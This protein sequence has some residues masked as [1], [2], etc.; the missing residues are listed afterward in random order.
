MVGRLTLMLVLGR[1]SITCIE[2]ETLFGK[3]GA[4]LSYSSTVLP[5]SWQ[6]CLAHFHIDIHDTSMLLLC[7]FAVIGM[8]GPFRSPD[9]FPRQPWAIFS[10]WTHHASSIDHGTPVLEHS[11]RSNNAR[12]MTDKGKPLDYMWCR[13]SRSKGLVDDS[14]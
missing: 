13:R 10:V 4:R 9:T 8:G 7:L 11:Y 2:L 3:Q 6:D 1:N 5:R 14:G 12:V